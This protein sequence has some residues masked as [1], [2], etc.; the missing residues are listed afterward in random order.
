QG[1][2]G[3][4]TVRFSPDSRLAL[5]EVLGRWSAWELDTGR[6]LVSKSGAEVFHAIHFGAAR[7]QALTIEAGG[8]LAMWDVY[9][10]EAIASFTGL[11]Q[12]VAA[13]FHPDGST[14]L[15]LDADG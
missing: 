13:S 5:A 6:R 1:W 11:G 8:K 4:S 9:T 7:T 15:T 12:P 14:G 2:D 10:G 3:V